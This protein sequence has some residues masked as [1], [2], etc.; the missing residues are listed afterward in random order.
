MLFRDLIHR[1][2]QPFAKIQPAVAFLAAAALTSTAQ[3]DVDLS[4]Q[5]VRLYDDFGGPFIQGPLV[6][7]GDKTLEPNGFALLI[8]YDEIEDAQLIVDGGSTLFAPRGLATYSYA[9]LPNAKAD[10]FVDGV[11]SRIEIA[12]EIAGGVR[13]GNI[14]LRGR[15][16]FYISNGGSVVWNDA[17]E[18]DGSFRS[19]DILIGDNNPATS[20]FTGVTNNGFQI[21]GTGSL[22]DASNTGGRLYVGFTLAPL[23]GQSEDFLVAQNGGEIRS[24]GAGIAHGWEGAAPWQPSDG[25]LRGLSAVDNGTWSIQAAAGENSNLNIGEGDGASGFL[26]IV[27]GGTV[28]V[29]ANGST[30]AGFFLGQSADGVPTRGADNLLIVS[31]AGSRLT[32]DDNFPGIS[33][34]R[35]ANGAVSIQ[36]SGSLQ[37]DSSILLVS[38]KTGRAV[39]S[40]FSQIAATEFGVTSLPGTRTLDVITGGSLAVTD[41]DSEGI[42]ALIIGQTP[43]AGAAQEAHVL[44]TGTVTVTNDPGRPKISLDATEFGIPRVSNIGTGT[45]EIGANGSVAFENGDFVI[46]VNLTDDATV[47]V[48]SGGQL[49]ADRIVV[50]FADFDSI[51][52]GVGVS[53]T[54]TLVLQDGV[55]NGDVIVDDHG[56]LAGVGTVNGAVIG[57]GGTIAPGFSPGTI[58]AQS[59]TLGPG[60]ELVLEVALNPDGTVNTALSDSLS[61]SDGGTI[62]LSNGEVTFELSSTDASVTVNEILATDQVLEVSELFESTEEVVVA[63]YNLTDPSGSVTDEEL[64]ARVQVVSFEKKECKKDGWMSLFRSDQTG[65]TNQGECIEYV[66]EG[67]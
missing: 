40:Y 61:V 30:E 62:D 3:A 27:N 19:C 36:D 32:V 42:S 64:E 29:I 18:C 6:L 53:E 15:G 67:I 50:G 17:N 28:N 49:T 24:N 44:V 1:G 45:L 14:F 48:G 20:N 55:V 37:L 34:S 51:G 54:G 22:L 8:Q 59:F 10:V 9:G 46:G 7:A 60:T 11:G 23:L 43:E 56:S 31:G 4:S 57:E 26:A 52:P 35:I 12:G 21:D 33:G 41:N 39:T 5:W 13:S 16:D 47:S 65:F 58:S 63:E 66:N 38:G 25:Y 2:C